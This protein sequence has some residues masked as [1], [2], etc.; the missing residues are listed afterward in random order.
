MNCEWEIEACLGCVG[1]WE[2]REEESQGGWIGEDRMDD[3][4]RMEMR[5][6]GR[7]RVDDDE[8]P[9]TRVF[10]TKMEKRDGEGKKEEEEEEEEER[11]RGG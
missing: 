1:G 2:D 4:D 3:E 5:G 11:A 6:G 9:T 7:V 8:G 10:Q